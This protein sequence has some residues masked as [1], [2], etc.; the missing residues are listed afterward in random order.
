MPLSSSFNAVTTKGSEVLI[1]NGLPKVSGRRKE[2]ELCTSHGA[3]SAGPPSGLCQ[4]LGGALG[5]ATTAASRGH[6]G[7]TALPMGRAGSEKRQNQ[8]PRALLY[9]WASGGKGKE[10][11]ESEESHTAASA[12]KKKDVICFYKKKKKIG[13]SIAERQRVNERQHRLLL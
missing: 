11:H 7:D 12:R 6:R 3:P 1:N 9:R 8:E 4:G 5:A 2:R 13:H 10:E